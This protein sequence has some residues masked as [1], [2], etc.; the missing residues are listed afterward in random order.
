LAGNRREILS[1]TAA[2]ISSMLG[3]K[4]AA[5]HNAGS[6]LVVWDIGS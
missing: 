2:I 6:H 5:T 1:R 4:R 3:I